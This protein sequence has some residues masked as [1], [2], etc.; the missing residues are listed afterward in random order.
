V[1]AATTGCLHVRKM[2]VA[3]TVQSTPVALTTKSG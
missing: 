1:A 3:V 2:T